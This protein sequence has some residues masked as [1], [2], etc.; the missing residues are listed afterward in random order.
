MNAEEIAFKRLEHVH[1]FFARVDAKASV[2][3]G[4]DIAMIGF[5][6]GDALAVSHWSWW[7]LI[8]LLPLSLLGVSL[9]YIYRCSFPALAGGA[10]SLLYFR[11]I[12]QHGEHAF[13][14]LYQAQD[15]AARVDD[16][17]CQIWRNSQIL[18]M[19]FDAL[20]MTHVYLAL[21]ILPW[22]ATLLLFAS[23]SAKSA[24]L[25]H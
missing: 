1:A 4:V 20:K 14:R 8:A 13:V 3:L 6:G 15:E 23:L 9:C 10:A 21:S 2:V 24:V 17:L 12:S 18:T 5:I 16:T 22:L 19:K 11:S 25:V 7:M